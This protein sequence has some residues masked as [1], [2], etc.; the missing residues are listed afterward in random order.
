LKDIKKVDAFLS[1]HSQSYVAST[2]K[3]TNTN[4]KTNPTGQGSQGGAAS[5]KTLTNHDARDSITA[6]SSTM[7]PFDIETALSALRENYPQ[8]AL[9]LAKKHG[10]HSWSEVDLYLFF[11]SIIYNDI[12][13][14]LSFESKLNRI[15]L[16]I[17]IVILK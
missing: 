12:Y 7:L 4:V 6:S 15:S 2:A 9:A 3:A 17:Y 1:L 14:Y 8:H 13:L 5:L 11:F 10:E 16:Y